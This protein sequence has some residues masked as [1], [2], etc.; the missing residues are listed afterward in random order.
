MQF[1]FHILCK[2]S[3]VILLDPVQSHK[4]F[5][6]ITLVLQILLVNYILVALFRLT[7]AGQWFPSN[8]MASGSLPSRT[9]WQ[10]SQLL[11]GN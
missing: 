5:N 7:L 9:K 3:E 1:A 4:S 10:H 6:K 8:G 2:K 11:S